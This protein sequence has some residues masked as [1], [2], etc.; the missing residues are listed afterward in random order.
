M[1]LSLRVGRE[2]VTITIGVRIGRQIDGI[3]TGS[4]LSMN[5]LRAEGGL[6]KIKPAT[7]ADFRNQ[8]GRLDQFRIN[9]GTI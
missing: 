9:T 2:M 6:R 7:R 5:G 1:R 3:L 8:S 4:I